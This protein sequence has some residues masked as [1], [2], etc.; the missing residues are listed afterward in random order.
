MKLL[1]KLAYSVVRGVMRFALR[2]VLNAL[3]EVAKGNQ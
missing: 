1:R 2:A 3:K